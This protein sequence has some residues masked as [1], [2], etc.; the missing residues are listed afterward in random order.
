MA[1]DNNQ[2]LISFPCDF[3]IK[4]FGLASDE[5]DGAVFSI[6]RKHVPRFSDTAFQSRSSENNRYRALSITVHVESKDQLDKIYKDLSASPEVLM[7]L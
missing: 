6:I 2:T 3:T 5:F 1:K 4:I 7:A